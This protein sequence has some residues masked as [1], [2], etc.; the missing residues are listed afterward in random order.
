MSDRPEARP[1]RLLA[2][3]SLALAVRVQAPG[4][5]SVSCQARDV[6]VGELFLATDTSPALSSAV[7]GQLTLPGGQI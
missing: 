3:S 1:R 7:S 6:S 2:R 4:L 5:P